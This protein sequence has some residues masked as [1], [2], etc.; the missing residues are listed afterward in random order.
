MAV[1]NAID[2]IV[3]SYHNLVKPIRIGDE[4]RL[5]TEGLQFS[6]SSMYRWVKGE[7]ICIKKKAGN[8]DE[9][10]DDDLVSSTEVPIYYAPKKLILL[11][12][13]ENIGR[14]M[15][16][17]MMPEEAQKLWSELLESPTDNIKKIFFDNY[18]ANCN[19]VG[20]TCSSI[21]Q[22]NI[23]FT[24]S[25]AT[26]RKNNKF[27]PTAFYK[28][29]REVFSK[30]D[31]DR[32]PRIKFDVVIQ[33]ESS[34]AT[35]AELSLP[36]IYGKKNII[37]GDHRQLPPML[38][39]ESFVNSFDYLIKHEK[40]N[41]ELQKIKELKSF[42]IKNFNILEV[43]HFER[44]YNQIDEHLKGV[45]NYQFRMHPAINEVIKQF[46]KDE[47]GLECGLT[48]PKDLGFNDPD[49]IHNGASRYHGITA[50]PISPDVHVL[51]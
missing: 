35:P 45:F 19:V 43:S 37:I 9:D 44:L 3:N 21:G 17:D 34:K 16:K 39:R 22:K 13:M 51:D 50:G 29:Y 20:A 11:N 12:W 1:D 4:S 10:E 36:L 6:Y 14:R 41:D 5:E 23:I 33:D 28:T 24:E 46:Y 26:S 7:D 49:Y 38:S 47:G 27:I 32:N 25:I 18:I 15:D 2:R 8:I 48:T 42:V 30:R 40:N 31:N